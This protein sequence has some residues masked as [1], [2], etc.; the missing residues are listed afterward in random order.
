MYL[1]I[2]RLIVWPKSD[3]FGPNQVEFKLNCVNVLSGESRT[4]K[5]AISS[6]IDYCLGSRDC[7]IPIGR[8][9]DNASWYGIVAM[10]EDKR[11]LFAR[12]NPTDTNVTNEAL[13][14]ELQK[15]DDIPLSIPAG[16]ED[17]HE[18]VNLLARIGGIP[19]IPRS[20]YGYQNERLSFRDTTHLLFQVQDIVAN[21][22]LLFYKMQKH[23]VMDKFSEWFNFIIGAETLA[24]VQFRQ[25]LANLNAQLKAMDAER[26]KDRRRLVKW[27]SRL[28]SRIA[29]AQS[30]G[31]CY[32]GET[33]P[34]DDKKLLAAAKLVL[35]RMKSTKAKDPSDAVLKELERRKEADKKC[36][37]EIAALEREVSALKELKDNIES[38]GS[39]TALM[40]DRLSI[41]RWLL[42]NA[43]PEKGVCPVCG[44]R[45]HGEANGELAKIAKV[46]EDCENALEGK[47]K[48]SAATLGEANKKKK[49]L[50]EAKARREKIQNDIKELA[51][52]RQQ[53]YNDY[54][55]RTNDI[56]ALEVELKD[57]VELND[58][59]ATAGMDDAEA[60]LRAR[61]QEI[62][63]QFDEKKIKE[64]EEQRLAKIG[65]LALQRLLTLDCEDEYRQFP[66]VLKKQEMNVYVRNANDKVAEGKKP[67][68]HILGEVGSASNWV[69]LHIAITCALQEFFAAMKDPRCCVPN[70]VIYDQPSQVYFPSGKLVN[71]DP[72]AKTTEELSADLSDEKDRESVRKMFETLAASIKATTENGQPWQAI[73]LEHAG[74]DIYGSVE[75]VNILEPWRNGKALIPH[76]WYEENA[77]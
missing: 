57:I 66:P 7:M 24:D 54:I 14:R 3:K 46:V 21:R 31:F 74:P 65:E 47:E 60:K 35:K 18:I 45:G 4:G 27:N 38:H 43:Q 72:N 39:V 37:D 55:Q 48:F 56:T 76:E 9:R 41:S 59:S 15:P 10:V 40:R 11:Y 32:E 1:Q 16:T 52:V 26:E 53:V 22:Y 77:D 44:E 28:R 63:A 19:D 8:V 62:Q 34:E 64:R 71:R 20:D 23:E 50:E 13:I 6:I 5:S 61:I 36:G 12:R 51:D 73:V 67:R 58:T 70:F 2:E 25:E 69:A 30:Y 49:L 68:E 17:A 33:I 42:R 29:L 75:G